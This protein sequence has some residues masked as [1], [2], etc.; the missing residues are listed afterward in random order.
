MFQ[1]IKEPSA[2]STVLIKCGRYDL[3]DFLKSMRSLSHDLEIKSV[4]SG[5]RD[6]NVYYLNQSCYD[7]QIKELS[8]N[9][10]MFLPL[11]RVKSFDGFSNGLEISDE[12][13]PDTSIYG[14]ISQNSESLK[15]FKKYFDTTDD[16]KMGLML[17]YPECCCRGYVDYT[18]RSPDPI[19]EIAQNTQHDLSTKYDPIVIRDIHWTLQSHMRYFEIKIIPF[20]PCNYYCD[21]AIESAKEWY[22]LLY[23]LDPNTVKGIQKLMLDPSTWSLYNSQVLIN[24]PPSKANF[25]G[26]AVSYYTP[27]KREVDFYP[28]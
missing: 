15:K 25:M 16:Y 24:R 8:E 10:L 21:E 13:G 14:V 27:E 4:T 6:V 11:A 9:G 3:I 22:N 19:Y 20:F 26:Y 2:F 18:R 7:E 12:I 5:L 1:K 28:I 17:G 23:S